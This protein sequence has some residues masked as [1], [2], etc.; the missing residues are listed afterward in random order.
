MPLCSAP[1]ECARLE[2]AP[3]DWPSVDAAF[4]RLPRLPLGQ[5]WLQE[6]EPGFRPAFARFGWREGWLYVEVEM[7]DRDV[8]NPVSRFNEPAYLKGDVVEVFLRAEGGPYY[9]ELHSTPGG[10]LFQ[11]RFLS[12]QPRVSRTLVTRP[13]ARALTRQTGGG[14][15]AC[16]E[17]PYELPGARPRPG[18]EWFGA[19][20]RYDYTRGEPAPVLSSTA[21]FAKRDF[22][23]LECWNRI[24]FK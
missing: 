10:S 4:A 15:S 11:L 19:V 22:H 6:P 16:L 9:C 14:W 8:F 2:T 3:S 23:Q 17:I 18:A 13:V 21:A 12:A 5:A 24:V 20:C 7:E 1:I